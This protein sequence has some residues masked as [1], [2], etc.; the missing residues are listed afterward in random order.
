MLIVRYNFI[1][2]IFIVSKIVD[3]TTNIIYNIFPLTNR[4]S[5][6]NIDLVESKNC[7]EH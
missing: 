4:H 2:F 5:T 1:L 3:E 7:Y 6:I